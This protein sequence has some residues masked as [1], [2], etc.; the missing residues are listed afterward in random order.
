M[1]SGIDSRCAREPDRALRRTTKVS[2][3]DP[4]GSQ[5]PGLAS[6][7]GRTVTAHFL[8]TGLSWPCLASSSERSLSALVPV[9]VRRPWNNPS[10]FQYLAQRKR[11]V[12]GRVA[13]APRLDYLCAPRW[14]PP[15][16]QQLATSPPTSPRVPPHSVEAFVGPGHPMRLAQFPENGPTLFQIVLLSAGA[17]PPC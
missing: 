16:G 14:D 15:P 2:A 17:G 3:G 8:E 13:H 4:G 9:A 7:P 10:L 5:S 12:P 11:S 1:P 6:L